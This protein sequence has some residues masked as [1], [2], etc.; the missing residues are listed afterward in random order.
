[1]A[2]H[3]AFAALIERKIAADEAAT[4]AHTERAA[5]AP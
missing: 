3:K 4:T 1:V 2:D 5:E